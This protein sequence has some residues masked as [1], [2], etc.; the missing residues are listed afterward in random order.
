MP[1]ERNV[2]NPCFVL[3]LRWMSRRCW[4]RTFYQ[5]E[6]RLGSSQYNAALFYDVRKSYSDRVVDHFLFTTWSRYWITGGL[7]RPYHRMHN[8]L[9][10]PGIRLER[11]MHG[12][13]FFGDQDLFR[14]SHFT[15][16][17][18]RSSGISADPGTFEKGHI[19]STLWRRTDAYKLLRRWNKRIET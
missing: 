19:S 15:S 2:V 11:N 14:R 1:E 17:F 13:W 10:L 18:C 12:Q 16:G 9:A 8:K 5:L 3:Y 4:L 6:K 7:W